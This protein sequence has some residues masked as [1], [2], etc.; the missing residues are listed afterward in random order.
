MSAAIQRPDL[1]APRR[2]RPGREA[3]GA[4]LPSPAAARGWTVGRVY[5][6][7][8][9]GAWSGRAGMGVPPMLADIKAGHVDTVVVWYLDRLTRR[10][11]ELKEFFEVYDAAGIRH[12]AC[13]TG[14]V[15]LTTHDGQFLARILGAVARKEC[16]T[17][18]AGPRRK[19]QELAGRAVGG[20]RRFGYESDRPP[21]SRGRAHPG[22]G[23]PVPAG[24]LLFAIA[25]DW[26]T[27]ALPTSS[28]GSG[29][30][31]SSGSEVGCGLLKARG[32][33]YAQDVLRIIPRAFHRSELVTKQ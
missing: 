24:E 23:R 29:T 7:K 10:P 15:E 25:A 16:T 1:R 32:R 22:G 28:G 2:R 26:N 6:H 31:S 27:R 30:D 9:V 11:I 19:R 14:D 5:I 8:N 13:V 21:A 18:A 3:P 4:G 17:R 12:L 33:E 20:A